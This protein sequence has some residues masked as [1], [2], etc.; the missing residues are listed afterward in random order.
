MSLDTSK[1]ITAVTYNGTTIPLAGGATGD[2]TITV[3]DYD[4]SIIEQVKKNEGDTYTLPTAPTHSDRTFDC[5]ISPK[6]LNN[7]NTL[8]V[9]KTN[10]VI[11]ATY[12]LNDPITTFKIK[13]SRLGQSAATSSYFNQFGVRVV[14]ITSPGSSNYID[15]GDGDTTSITSSGQEYSHLYASVGEYTVKVSG[16]IQLGYCVGGQNIIE[17]D[18]YS[19]HIGGDS[20]SSGSMELTYCGSLKHCSIDNTTTAKLSTSFFYGGVA[21]E[22]FILPQNCY[23]PTSDMGG[24][25]LLYSSQLKYVVLNYDLTSVNSLIGGEGVYIQMGNFTLSDSLTTIPEQIAYSTRMENLVI[26]TGVT[27][28]GMPSAL[29]MAEKKIYF[30]NGF[31]SFGSSMSSYSNLLNYINDT[32]LD[33]S[34][35]MVTTFPAGALIGNSYNNGRPSRLTKVKFSNISTISGYYEPSSGNQTYVI[36]QYAPSIVELDFSKCTSVPQ[37]SDSTWSGYFIDNQYNSFDFKII[38]PYG[39]L[40]VWQSDSHWSNVADFMVEAPASVA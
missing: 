26:P 19:G 36:M 33:F 11:G 25:G 30:P 35:T 6:Q 21:L 39:M 3:I 14:N 7:G 4:G 27:S 10:V 34:N 12:I 1:T 16:L 2:Y 13:I 24:G 23:L 31:V 9:G 22:S 18:I 28:I 40:S 29:S 5:W 15:W 20:M 38:V 17:A 32:E 37:P 8:T